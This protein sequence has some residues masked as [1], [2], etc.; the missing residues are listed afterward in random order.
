M[1][2]PML[3]SKFSKGVFESNRKWFVS[4]KYD[5]WRMIYQNGKFF[6]RQG[7]E[8]S[9]DP[10]M[11][12]DLQDIDPDII[13]DGELWAG[14][15]KVNEVASLGSELKFLIFDIINDS[16]FSERLKTLKNLI[17][18][19]KRIKLVEH[20]PVT[21][22]NYPFVEDLLSEV[23]KR[24]GE[25][26]VLR[27]ANQLYQSGARPSDFL[28]LKK[29]DTTEVE[30][31]GYYTTPS[32]K[33]SEGPDYIS[34]L[35]CDYNGSE[36][37]L[38]WRSFIAPKIGTI[39]TIKFSQ[40]TV[41]GLPK[42]PIYVAKRDARDLKVSSKPRELKEPK[43]RKSSTTFDKPAVCMEAKDW[44]VLEYPLRIGESVGVIG[45]KDTWKVTKAKNGS[46]YCS[47]PAWLYQRM[48]AINRTC[49]HTRIF[50]S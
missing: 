35:V 47:C 1:I 34:S 3:L 13:L 20:F 6:T 45:A 5:G 18:P 21:F 30:V 28:K 23:S 14:Y 16:P 26:L 36:F 42:F 32:K 19:T 12:R 27:P 22:D 10:K 2:S 44:E 17:T 15:S 39:I 31:V 25:G 9:L 46:V 8:I 4:E 41:N 38:N 33:V 7:N 48:P 40:F 29:M 11:Y 50:T 49:K 43:V 24:D 37:K